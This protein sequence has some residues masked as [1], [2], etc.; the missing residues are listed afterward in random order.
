MGN[1]TKPSVATKE[2]ASY[3]GISPKTCFIK[4]VDLL[5]RASLVDHIVASCTVYV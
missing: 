3:C 4:Q 1:L 5:E 2:Q